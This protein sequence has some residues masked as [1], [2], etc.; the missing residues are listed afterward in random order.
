MKNIFTFLFFFGLI[1][2]LAFSQDGDHTGGGGRFSKNIEYNLLILESV[3]NFN[4]KGDVEKL[5]FGDFNAPV[6]FFYEPSFE[7]AS[8]FRIVRDTLKESYI[9]EIKYIS[10]YKEAESEVSKKYSMRS[11][12]GEERESMSED[13]FSSIIEYN[14]KMIRMY[15]EEMNK[16]YN[17]ENRVF[18]VSDQFAK[19]MYEKMFSVIDNFKAR[20]VPPMI[21][22]GV[23]VTFR[24]VVDDEVWS[25]R[26]HEPTGR[27][28]KFA[29]F[30]LKIIKETFSVGK[31]DETNYIKLLDDF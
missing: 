29:D 9:L 22:D 16:L 19:K 11:I 20:G 25:L 23:H 24:N 1:T 31:P 18:L 30:C 3:Y 4:S 5:F 17:I 27:A 6:E 15:F 12:S 14:R 7:G 28:Q 8:G 10:N 21:S 26:I 2:Q 13:T